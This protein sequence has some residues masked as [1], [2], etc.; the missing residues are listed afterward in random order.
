MNAR[1]TPIVM[2]ARVFASFMFVFS[3]I[4]RFCAVYVR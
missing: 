3:N 1:I 4:V 2:I